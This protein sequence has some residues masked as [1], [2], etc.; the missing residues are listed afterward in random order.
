MLDLTKLNKEQLKAVKTI[1][2]PV[3]VIAGAGSGK[4]R[5]LTY[6]IAYMI[7]EGINPQSIVAVTFTNKA[8]NE[9][10]DRVVKL[11][12]EDGLLTQVSTFH[13]FCARF[14]RDEIEHLK[15]KF[16]RRYLIID[17]EDSKQIIRD[18]VR[19]L[20]Y[21][22]NEYKSSRL[23]DLFSRYKN[24]QMDILKPA[25]LDIY[26]AYNQYLENNN[27]LDFDDIILLT[28]ENLKKNDELRAYYNHRYQYILVDEFQDTNIKQYELIKLLVGDNK[29]IFIVGDPDQSIYSFRGANI[30]NQTRFMKEYN[31]EV[32]ILDQNYRSTMKILSGANNLISYNFERTAEK[33][34]RS[35]LGEGTDIH[36]EVRQSDRDEAYFV[37]RAIDHYIFRGYDYKDIAVLY[38]SNAISRVFEES[39]IKEKIPYVI[40]GGISFFSRK[41]VKDILAYL[42]VC[43]NPHDNISIKRIINT[44]RRKIGQ[45]TINKL[46][47]YGSIY[48]MSLFDSIDHIGIKGGA[49]QSLLEFKSLIQKMQKKIK[50]TNDL[51][52]IIDI[53]NELSGYK[54]MLESEGAESKDRLENIQE[55][56]AIFYYGAEEFAGLET[57][58]AIEKILEDISLKTDLDIDRSDNTVKLATVHQVKGLEFKIVFIVA[59]EDGIFPVESSLMS[60]V[61]LEEERRVFYVAVTRAKEQLIISNSQE[62]YRFGQT[63]M[64]MP[65]RFIKEMG[66]T[67]HVKEPAKHTP[68]Q[69]IK[70]EKKKEEPKE[71]IKPGD[72]VSHEKYGLGVAVEVTEDITKIAFGFDHGIK[73]FVTGH[74]SIKKVN[75][76]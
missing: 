6:R 34:L 30:K 26:K 57:L 54:Q 70:V 39:F 44:P 58:E 38:R 71:D 72:R 53:V 14:L 7:S 25:E 52:V 43:L 51:P 49:K 5:T 59:A 65:T 62:R 15:R 10:K 17:E 63:K 36:Y 76:T 40:Y 2:G 33:N 24:G 32:I 42:R 67:S 9:M 55:L 74:P 11:V 18:T 23:K 8:A 41:E 21:D 19:E 3:A 64:Y 27:S 61:D 45:V 56:K 75:K 48:N 35:D 73:L 60:L 69:T 31:P 13:S 1:H 16:T 22:P 47:K 68:P 66:I 4:T 28:I 50:E 37:S 20:N 12:G 46:E 29:N